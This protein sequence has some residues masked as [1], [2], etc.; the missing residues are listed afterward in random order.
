MRNDNL[1]IVKAKITIKTAEA[2]GRKS[3]FFSGYRPDHV[4]EMPAN[5]VF[6]QS[7]MGD[8]Q[9]SEQDLIMPGEIKIVTIRFLRRAEIEKYMQVGQTWFIMEGVKIIG[10]GEILEV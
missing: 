3:G 8:I 4:F 9:F 6:L 10:F 7:F 5:K 1:I 2:G